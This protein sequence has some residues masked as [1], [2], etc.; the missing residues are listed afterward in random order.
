M[1][2]HNALRGA[3]QVDDGTAGT[4]AHRYRLLADYTSDVV[5]LIGADGQVQWISPSVRRVLGWSAE[6]LI[7]SVLW[8]LLHPDDRV[9]ADR[10]HQAIDRDLE[11]SDG[12]LARIRHRDG[13]YRWMTVDGRRI[14]ADGRLAGLAG[15]L[16]DVTREHDAAAAL[17]AGQARYRMLVDNSPD[18]VFHQVDGVMEWIS[19]TVE[20]LLGWTAEDLV[21]QVT[22]HLWHPDDRMRAVALREEVSAGG[23]GREVLRFQST[24]CGWR[25]PFIPPAPRRAPG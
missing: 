12:Y 7:G 3:S 22:E 23:E 20:D 15:A 19:P 14:I 8:D 9:R 11:V 2:M 24:S 4:L 6:G 1:T 18:V 16:H 13:S 5:Y 25:R 10:V 21:G 17:A